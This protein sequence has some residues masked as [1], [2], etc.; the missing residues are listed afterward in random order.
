MSDWSVQD[1]Y[2]TPV[3]L[4]DIDNFDSIQ[5]EI[6]GIVEKFKFEYF[7]GFGN[8]HKLSEHFS[9]DEKKYLMGDL[10]LF[11]DELKNHI[12]RY[13][14]QLN[15]NTREYQFVNSWMTLFEKGDYAHIH[16]HNDVDF[17]G[18]YY[19]QKESDIDDFF[20][21]SPVEGAKSSAAYYGGRIYP[22]THTGLLMLFP[23]WLSHGVNRIETDGKRYSISFNIEFQ[24]FRDTLPINVL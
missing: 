22:P 13:C 5:N 6:S 16:N 4:A 9:P 19:Y 23:G 7:P 2:P 17:S 3:Y 8:T 24:K 21:E 11:V 15:F 10:P 18:V 20:F 12:S 14:Q 1:I